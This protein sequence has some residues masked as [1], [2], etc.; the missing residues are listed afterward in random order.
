[1]DIVTAL[2]TFLVVTIVICVGLLIAF[3]LVYLKHRNSSGGFVAEKQ[4]ADGLDKDLA[5]EKQRADKLDK[6]FVAEKQRAD[7]LD[8]NLERLRES[9]A[10]LKKRASFLK[11][12]FESKEVKLKLEELK[13][14]V[15]KAENKEKWI[16]LGRTALKAL[17]MV[18]SAAGGFPGIDGFP[19]DPF[20]FSNIGDRGDNFDIDGF[21]SANS[22][23]FESLLAG[24][25]GVSEL[26]D[27]KL[28]SVPLE[29]LE[30]YEAQLVDASQKL[31]TTLASFDI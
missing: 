6:D 11:C 28:S 15:R 16:K 18:G 7:K 22:K 26:D 23:H 21:L 14:K 25:E 20:L 3:C 9:E 5:V 19:N 24:L 12:K 29:N 27:E 2:T 10:T 1:M 31:D 13:E 17:W 4:R 8:R 30:A